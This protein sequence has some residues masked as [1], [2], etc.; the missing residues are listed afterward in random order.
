VWSEQSLPV[1][2][3]GSDSGPIQIV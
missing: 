2:K 1:R 3:N